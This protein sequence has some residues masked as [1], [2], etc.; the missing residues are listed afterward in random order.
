MLLIR[1]TVRFN[2]LS[3]LHEYNCKTCGLAHIEEHGQ[4]LEITPNRNR[5]GS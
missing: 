5:I 2:G 1:K 4:A 3:D